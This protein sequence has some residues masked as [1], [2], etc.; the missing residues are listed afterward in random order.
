MPFD[1]PTGL[2]TSGPTVEVYNAAGNVDRV[3]DTGESFSI[4][5]DW[6]IS[7]GSAPLLAGTWTVRAFAE[8]VGPGPEVL[9]GTASV[10]LAGPLSFS[11][12]IP[13]PAPA[14]NQ[15]PSGPPPIS[16]VYKI[17]TV[18]T[19]TNA[20]G[21]ATEMAGFEEGPVIQMRTP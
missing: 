19:H 18:I 15:L 3:L 21:A 6:A 9:L 1:V 8:S 12:T 10:A 14:G 13:I 20:F 7:G 11:A 17:V 5:I 2:T 4:Q 16:G